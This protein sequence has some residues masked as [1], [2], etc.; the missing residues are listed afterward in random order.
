ML[1]GMTPLL[2][3]HVA[4]SLVGIASGFVVIW[5]LLNA[6]RLDGWTAVFLATTVATSVTGFFLPAAHLLPSH[7][8]GIISLVVLAIAIVA[9]YPCRLSGRWRSAYVI[10]AVIAQYLN[11]LVLIVQSFQKLPA[12]HDLAP[13]QTEPPFAAAQL[14]ALI[15]FVVLGVLAVKR[16]DVEPASA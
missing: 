5:G 13:T 1:F 14:V 10:T 4:I 7:V 8:L 12:L 11:F 2:F 9:R 15:A 3:V 16:F 6:R